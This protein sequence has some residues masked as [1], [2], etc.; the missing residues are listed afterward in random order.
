MNLTI[1]ENNVIKKLPA[2]LQEFVVAKFKKQICAY[3]PQDLETRV[4]ALIIKT[5]V[6]SG[7][8]D[9]TDI[10]VISFL[11]N[12]LFEDL[13]HP[14]Y[15]KL[16]FEEIELALKKGVRQEYG[17]YMGVNIQTIHSWL[18]AYLTS[19]DRETAIKDFYRL[20]DENEFG[21][22]DRSAKV[23]PDGQK[24][25]LEML[26]PLTE[27]KKISYVHKDKP[28]PQKSPRDIFIQ[29]CFREFFELHKRNAIKQSDGKDSR[30]IVFDGQ[31]VD[32]AEYTQIKLK[33]WD[34]INN[35][36]ELGI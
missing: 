11:K 29:E 32:E 9:Q 3:A 4:G 12:T 20:A 34:L 13:K 7:V 1:I 23:N 5:L 26:R 18:K 16:T 10:K 28:A 25:L 35:K 15:Q 27:D 36:R 2:G 19:K 31:A 33:E 22:D 30:F 8:K 17:V 24:K 21:K 14:R 6:E